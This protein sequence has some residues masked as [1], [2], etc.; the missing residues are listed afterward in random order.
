MSTTIPRIHRDTAAPLDD[1]DLLLEPEMDAQRGMR[2]TRLHG[3]LLVCR[4][5]P[6]YAANNITSKATGPA[7]APLGKRRRMTMLCRSPE[8][9][10]PK[11]A[12]SP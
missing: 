3:F 5:R 12:H 4:N 7:C 8:R 11:D 10:G 6:Y 9:P 2:L 1:T